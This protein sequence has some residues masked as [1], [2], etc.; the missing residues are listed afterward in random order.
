MELKNTDEERNNQHRPLGLGSTIFWMA[1]R[2]HDDAVL[3]LY[4]RQLLHPELRDRTRERPNAAVSALIFLKYMTNAGGFAHQINL[5][6]GKMTESMSLMIASAAHSGPVSM[7]NR[8]IAIIM[9][10]EMTHQLF[11]KQQRPVAAA[12]HIGRWDRGGA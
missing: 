6:L 9:N 8:T 5:T 11:E 2:N 1:L 12:T 3:R 10:Q 4:T 7:Q